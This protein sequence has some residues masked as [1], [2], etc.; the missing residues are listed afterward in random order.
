MTKQAG[1]RQAGAGAPRAILVIAVVAAL[2]SLFAIE[3]TRYG[4]IRRLRDTANTLQED[5]RSANAKADAALSAVIS[6]QSLSAAQASVYL[7]VV[8]GFPRGTAFVIDRDK[9]MLATAAH[10]ADS[11]PLSPPQSQGDEEQSIQIVNRLSASPLPVRSKKLHAGYGAFRN[12]VED[13]QPLRKNS[14]IY[15]P[16]AAPLRDLAFDAGLLFVDPI[17]PET[18]ENRLGP[19]LN[20]ASEEE[21]LTLEAGAP[22]AVIGFPYDTLDDGFAQDAGIARVERGVIAAMTPPLD[23]F[24]DGRDARTANLIIHRLATAGGSS[25]SPILDAYGRVVGIHTHGIESM[26]SNAD[27]AAQRAE[28]IYDLLDPARE[29]DRLQNL[30]YPSWKRLLSFWARAEDVLPWSFFMEYAQPGR[31]PAPLVGEYDFDAATPFAKSVERLR[32]EPKA[33]SRRVDASDVAGAAAISGENTSAPIAKD[34]TFLL[35]GEGQYAEIWRTVDRSKENVLF[36]F[37]YSLRS[38]R[39]FCPLTSFWRK[40]GETRLRAMPARASFELHLAAEGNRSEDYQIILKRNP[41]CDPLSDEFFVGAISW[42]DSDGPAVVSIAHRDRTAPIHASASV[43]TR[44]TDLRQSISRFVT[45]RLK[46]GEKPERCQKPVYVDLDTGTS[47]K[48][49]ETDREI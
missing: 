28:V 19:N 32:F 30:F 48:P 43:S 41:G 14:S 18:G 4:E 8:N 2:I 27:G 25:G 46:V 7:I 38:R 29:E 33:D 1:A 17:D 20:I 47:V 9:G 6:P 15:G 39:G 3:T 23:N 11:L 31:E 45:C 22:I 13:Y 36:A 40:K 37:D 49:V 44:L 16:Q 34:A 10:T 12:L 5:V 21:L 35:E 24:Q 42:T 26:S